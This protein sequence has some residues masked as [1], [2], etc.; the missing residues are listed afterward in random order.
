MNRIASFDRP[1]PVKLT[2]G[3]FALL[4]GSGAF[5]AYRKTELIEGRSTRCRDRPVR[6]PSR[7]MN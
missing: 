1:Q 6:I 7:Q 5:D 2:V 3:Q 4:D